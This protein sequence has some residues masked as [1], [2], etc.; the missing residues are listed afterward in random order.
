MAQMNLSTEQK[1]TNMENRLAVAKWGGGNGEG[2]GWT[3]FGVSR[4]KLL[5]SG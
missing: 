1:H 3:D 2:M 4:C 5:H